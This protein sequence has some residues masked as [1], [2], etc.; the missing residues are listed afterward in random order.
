MEGIWETHVQIAN[1]WITF[2]QNFRV[3]LENSTA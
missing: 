1:L 2:A 3:T